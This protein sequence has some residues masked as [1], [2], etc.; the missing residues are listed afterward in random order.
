MSDKVAL[1]DIF[2]FLITCEHGGNRIPQCYQQFFGGFESL[3]RS[4]R[5]YD[6]GTLRMA[7]ELAKALDAPLFAGTTSRL[8]IDLNRSLRHPQLYSKAIQSA[9][10]EVR[11][12]ILARHYM[13]YR[14]VAEA[15]I[16]EAIGRGEKIIHISSHSFTPELNGQIR[17][18]DIGLLYDP[19]RPLERDLCMR[20]QANLKARAANL[21]VRRN[22]PYAG[23][24]DGFVTYLRRR[25]SAD[26]YVGIEL[27]INQKHVLEGGPQWRE[28]RSVVLETLQKAVA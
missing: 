14:T 15:S 11:S 8:L 17:N 16:A 22:Y 4:H 18:A 21:T 1:T 2:N 27:E 10:V 13:P 6:R 24:A 3:L 20:W 26:T 5:G 9:P 7:K 23:R 19:S 28:L 25:F 12:E